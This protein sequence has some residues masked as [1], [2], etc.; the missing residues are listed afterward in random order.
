MIQLLSSSCNDKDRSFIKK[1]IRKLKIKIKQSSKNQKFNEIDEESSLSDSKLTI[2]TDEDREE[3]IRINHNNN[4]VR[5]NM[6]LEIFETNTTTNNN[7][8]TTTND[9]NDINAMLWYS[10]DEIKFMKSK[11]SIFVEHMREKQ[12]CHH[13]DNVTL[14]KMLENHSN[15]NY[16]IQGIEAMIDDD[17]HC[18]RIENIKQGIEAVLGEQ[19]KNNHKKRRRRKQNSSDERKINDIANCYIESGNTIRCQQEARS[20][21]IEYHDNLMIVSPTSIVV[22]PEV[23]QTKMIEI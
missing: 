17:I 21:G 13:Y 16:T 11:M 1:T 7:N 22:S 18:Q 19:Q 4:A 12:I 23:V 10:R 8:A 2:N 5:F 20:R 15:N 3:I 14:E 6:N 9:Y